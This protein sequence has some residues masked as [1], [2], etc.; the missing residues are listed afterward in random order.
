M[1]I[2]VVDK[3]ASFRKKLR[4][5]LADG[6]H[7]PEN[8]L[9]AGSGQA[10][11]EL[12]RREEFNIDAIVCEWDQA[13][14]GAS[15]LIQQLRAVPGFAHIGFIAVGPPTPAQEK[16]A[17]SNGATQYIPQPVDPEVLLQSLVEIEKKAI[18]NR[19]RAPSPTTRFRILANEPPGRMQPPA[20]AMGTAEAELRRGSKSSY[21]KPGGTMELHAGAPLHWI[22]SGNVE[23][24]E[25]RADGISLEYRLGPGQFFAE[26]PF[27]GF[28][29]SSITLRAEGEVWLSTRDALT[30][31]DLRKRHPVLFY[32]FRNI[33]TE[34]ARRFQKADERKAVERGLA[35]EVESLPVGDLMGILHGARKT[36]VLRLQTPEKTWYIQFT[37]GSVRHAEADGE[38]GEE[39]FYEALLQSKGRF[40]FMVGPA[41]EGP[42]TIAKDTPSLLLEGLK[43]RA[44]H[45]SRA[46]RTKGEE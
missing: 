41:V 10:A 23:V 11:M 44:M 42:V 29:F 38:L 17:K 3:L 4:A 24:S 40:E 5:W 16:A 13:A 19:K 33:A 28:P 37:S 46:P 36:G 12:L 43:R 21:L 34:R 2:L 35:G 9:E 31:D 18:A 1:R 22:E 6:G 26:S 32:S 8:M 7:A 20:A 15:D 30:V 14:V 39:V 25:V 45:A 27:G